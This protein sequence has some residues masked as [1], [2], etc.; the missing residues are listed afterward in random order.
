MPHLA[1]FPVLLQCNRRNQGYRPEQKSGR[2]RNRVEQPFNVEIV[3][4]KTK[5]AII[6]G[7]VRTVEDA[8]EAW[9]SDHQEAMCVR[10]IEEIIE[11]CLAWPRM[12]KQ[13]YGQLWDAAFEHELP[14]I[15]RFA[16]HIMSTSQEAVSALSRLA[17]CIE[18]AKLSG[19]AVDN[20]A[21]FASVKQQ[22]DHLVSEFQRDWPSIN[23]TAVSEAIKALSNGH[24]LTFEEASRGCSG[25]QN[26]HRPTRRARVVS[27][28]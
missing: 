15:Q 7:Q 14:S 18:W 23:G 1:Y 21:G 13:V 24:F 4:M 2:S 6:K 25:R 17:S 3:A 20:E 8:V 10:D 22:V 12:F 11:M 27:N 26:R 28:N 16:S 9:Q 5:H 19:Y